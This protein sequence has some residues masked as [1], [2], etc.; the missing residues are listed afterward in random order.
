MNRLRRA[1]AFYG[2]ENAST[3][4]MGDYSNLVYK[5]EAEQAYAL[6]IYPPDMTRE[7]IVTEVSWLTALRQDTE[8][9]V[10]KPVINKQGELISQLED[11]FCVLFDWLDGE[12]VSQTMSLKVASQIG[13][14]KYRPKNYSGTRY[15]CAY[16]FG[17]DSWWQVKAQERLRNDYQSLVPAIKKAECLMQR[18]G[19]SPQQF[20][21]IHSDIH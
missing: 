6:K 16:F 15:D 1:L 14:L 12:P 21:L 5:I 2:L 20:G 4:L 19:E 18:L 13:E 7:R 3:L 17:S 10:P 9:L 8:L 11:R